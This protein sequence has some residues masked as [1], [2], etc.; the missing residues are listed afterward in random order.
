MTDG[1]RNQ[2]NK[3]SVFDETSGDLAVLT[4]VLCSELN[5][6]VLNFPTLLSHGQPDSF[7]FYRQLIIIWEKHVGSHWLIRMQPITEL[8]KPYA[9]EPDRLCNTNIT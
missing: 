4:S 6:T 5:F 3:T 9:P 2:H 8:G 7:Y 1:R